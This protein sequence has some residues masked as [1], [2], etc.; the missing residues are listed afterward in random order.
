MSTIPSL[1]FEPLAYN[2]G[3]AYS[4]LPTDGTGD[5][6]VSRNTVCQEINS[7]GASVDVA[8]NVP[9]YDFKAPYVVPTDNSYYQFGVGKYATLPNPTVSAVTNPFSAI[10]KFKTGSDVTTEQGLYSNVV[11][12]SNRLNLNIVAGKIVLETFDGVR[13]AVSFTVAVNTE[14]TIAVTKPNTNTGT[15]KIYIN[16]SLQVD[17]GAE[18]TS[19]R[20]T[21]GERFGSLTDN[22][23]YFLGEIYTAE[24]YNI[25]LTAQ[26]GTDI[27]N[28]LPIPDKYVG[29]NNVDLVTNGGFTG[30][31]TGWVLQTGWVYGS[32][33]IVSTA[34]STAT[35]QSFNYKINKTY[36]VT[37]TISGYSSGTLRVLIGA[38]HSGAYRSSNGTFTEEITVTNPLFTDDFVI[39]GSVLTATFTDVSCVEIGNT[40]NLSKGKTASTW[41]DLDHNI[42]GAVTGAT[43]ND[44]TDFGNNLHETETCPVLLTEPSFTNYFINSATP[45]TQTITTVVGTEYTINCKGVGYITYDEVGGNGMGGTVT[46]VY[47]STY[48]ATATSVTVTLVGG[49][50]FDFVQLSNT[51]YA[52][53]HV[54][55]AGESLTKALDAVTGAGVAATYN[56]VEGVL[57]VEMSALFDDGTF[58]YISISDGTVNN[59]LYIGY[60][61][62][63]STIYF[64]VQISGVTVYSHSEIVSD[65]T[66]YNILKLKYKSGDYGS[67][68]N[69]V[70]V[71]SQS[72]GAGF[73]ENILTTTN[74]N[75]GSGLSVLYARTKS[76]IAH[77]GITNY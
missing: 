34:A 51:S 70:E 71:D 11:D 50:A 62:I 52:M 10:I 16:G 56:S 64:N 40:L 32:N 25:E 29:A 55:T 60:I 38:Y 14:Y 48:T 13:S 2:T 42:Q 31:T 46:E 5:F 68:I 22:T 53:N 27:Y 43:L 26:E 67:K 9:R 6:T 24:T 57:E 33:N 8:V 74:F 17:E 58:R 66:D 59:R 23:N 77:N 20:S 7:V 75:S 19:L 3:V 37:Y 44:S 1:K 61:S 47:P 35:L 63:S 54:P 69:G 65:I 28:G 18:F 4:Q 45:V 41:Y 76:V 21:L 49:H 73:S 12:G 72:S 15:K 36:R 30:G 39:S